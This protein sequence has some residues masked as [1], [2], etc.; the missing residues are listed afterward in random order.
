M[1]KVIRP[2]A[3]FIMLSIAVTGCQKENETLL[4]Y[5]V[6]VQQAGVS[7]SYTYGSDTWSATLN[8]NGDWYNFLDRM[9]ALAMEGYTVVITPSASAVTTDTKETVVFTTTD[10]AEAEAWTKS[11]VMDGYS[12][13]IQYDDKTG[14]YTCTAVK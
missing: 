8:D 9:F 10:K 12:V 13:S 1:K 3:F 4:P 7:V 11:M 6:A 5:N 14:A 2:L